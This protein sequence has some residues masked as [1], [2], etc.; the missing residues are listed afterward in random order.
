MQITYPITHYLNTY[1]ARFAP[2]NWT[3]GCAELVN[4]QKLRGNSD[5]NTT[6]IH[7]MGLMPEPVPRRSVVKPSGHVSSQEGHN[8]HPLEG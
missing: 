5:T 8:I 7:L 6:Q 4:R 3:E 2:L 1:I